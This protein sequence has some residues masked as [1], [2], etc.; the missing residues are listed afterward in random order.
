MRATDLSPFYRS[1]VGFDRLFNM[2]DTATNEASNQSYPPYNIEK[3]GEDAYLITVAVAGFSDDELE[4][5]VH[6]HT[7]RVSGKKATKDDKAEYLHRGIATRNFERRFELAEHVEVSGAN[8]ENGLLNIGLIREVP[9]A[10]KP[11]LVNI[12]SSKS[13][14]Q[15]IAAE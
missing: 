7:L 12:Q 13:K 15:T 2:L 1:S 8:V 6:N 9:D 5:E 14:P 3:T 10:L 11:R 4:V